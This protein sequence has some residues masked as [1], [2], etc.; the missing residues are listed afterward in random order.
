MIHLLHD[1]HEAY[2]GDI[3]APMKRVESLHAAIAEIEE[4]LQRAI[5]VAL[6]VPW[7]DEDE[8]HLIKQADTLASIVEA[9]HLLPS[10]GAHWDIPPSEVPGIILDTFNAPLPPMQAYEQFMETYCDLVA[11]RPLEALCA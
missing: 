9:H 10:R 6:N 1:A 7:P 11:G 5:H 4:R 8:A 2:T 3:V